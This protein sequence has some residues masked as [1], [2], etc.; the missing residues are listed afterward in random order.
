MSQLTLLLPLLVFYPWGFLMDGRKIIIIPV[1]PF[2]IRLGVIGIILPSRLTT[3][4]RVINSWWWTH[5]SCI[6]I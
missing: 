2:V 5:N 6:L 1:K 3:T 4:Q